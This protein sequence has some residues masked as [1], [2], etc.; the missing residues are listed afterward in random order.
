MKTYNVYYASK[1]N[2]TEK[3]FV[4]DV[5]AANAKEACAECKR[6][7]FENTGRNAFCPKAYLASSGKKPDYISKA[8]PGY[9]P[10]K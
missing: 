3:V 6:L 5:E 8:I 1:F 9:P 10:H 2:S 7:V 4:L